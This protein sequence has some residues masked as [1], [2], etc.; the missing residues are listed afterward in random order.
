MQD[1]LLY[2]ILAKL[3]PAERSDRR[4]MYTDSPESAAET[5]PEVPLPDDPLSPPLLASRW[6]SG[7]LRG[8]DMPGIAADLLEAGYDSHSLRLA[9]ELEASNSAAL[10]PLVGAM[11]RELDVNYPMSEREAKIIVSREIAREVIAGKRNPW[12]AANHLEIAYGIGCPR[13][14]NW[15]SSSR[16]TTRW[17]GTATRSALFLS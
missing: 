15:S 11:F 3:T 13:L 12:A 5:F 4:T 7:D 1:S 17:I 10:E 9:G 8:E 2:R 14:P 16:S 6:V